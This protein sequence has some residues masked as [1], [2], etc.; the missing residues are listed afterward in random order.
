MTTDM[1]RQ[2]FVNGNYGVD[3]VPLNPFPVGETFATTFPDQGWG[4]EIV[5]AQT[6]HPCER[7]A[8]AKFDVWAREGR[9][10]EH[11]PFPTN[12]NGEELC[13]GTILGTNQIDG[14]R[15]PERQQ[16][17]ERSLAMQSEIALRRWLKVRN[18]TDSKARREDY[19]GL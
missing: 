3:L 14:V 12:A 11:V 9:R 10:L 8:E 4:A 19:F 18:V 17:S 16:F 15:F 2:M 5:H 7:L 1:K 6:A 13:H